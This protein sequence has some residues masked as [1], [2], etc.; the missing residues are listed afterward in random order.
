MAWIVGLTAEGPVVGSNDGRLTL[1]AI[2]SVS[3][4]CAKAP[5]PPPRISSDRN[6]AAPSASV[7]RRFILIMLPLHPSRSFPK[8]S[9]ASLLGDLID[10]PTLAVVVRHTFAFANLP[11][12]PIIHAVS[13]SVRSARSM[14]S[15]YVLLEWS[16][17]SAPSRANL[18]WH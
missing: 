10:S 3:L 1:K 18:I 12:G 6:V 9:R 13:Y 15:P 16:R 5:P 17:F 7:S 4:V 14:S 8:L 2:V 11:L